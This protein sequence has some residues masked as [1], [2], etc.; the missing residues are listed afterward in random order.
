MIDRVEK[1]C[2]DQIQRDPHMRESVFHE[3][4]KV[5]WTLEGFAQFAAGFRG[6]IV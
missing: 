3:A 1:E 2:I 4:M 6:S 5:Q